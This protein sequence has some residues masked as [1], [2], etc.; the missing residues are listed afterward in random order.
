MLLYN[1]FE[2][3]IDLLVC[4]IQYVYYMTRVIDKFV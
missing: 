4:D 1:D 2:F 3:Y